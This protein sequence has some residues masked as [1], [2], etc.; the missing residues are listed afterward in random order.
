M[1]PILQ[2]F[3]KFW[4]RES[5]QWA[6][7][8]GIAMDDTPEE[9]VRPNYSGE[10]RESMYDHRLNKRKVRVQCF[11]ETFFVVLGKF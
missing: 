7:T 6:L 5:S 2:L 3:V 8:W 4:E 10:L 1:P 11:Y 9:T